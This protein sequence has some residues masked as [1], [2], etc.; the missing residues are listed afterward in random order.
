MKKLLLFIYALCMSVSTFAQTG[1]YFV[2]ASRPDDTGAG[3]SWATAKKTISAALTLIAAPGSYK[4]LFIAQG[5]Y[6]TQFTGSDR[7]INFYGGFPTG[8]GDGTFAARNWRTYPTIL[9]GNYPTNTVVSAFSFSSNAIVFD[10]FIVQNCYTNGSG[11]AS[12]IQ[13]SSS[14]GV[15]SNCIIRGCA[16]AGG[17]ANG[18]SAVKLT[19]TVG[20]TTVSSAMIKDCE[21]YANYTATTNRSYGG[22]GVH[23]LDG[24]TV[25]NCKIYN[26]SQLY[27]NPTTGPNG[28]SGAIYIQNS[29]NTQ[30]LK[31]NVYVVGNVIY[32]NSA[33]TG[34]GIFINLSQTN[35]AT[36]STIYIVNNTFA[37]NKAL[38]GTDGFLK[39]TLAQITGVDNTARARINVNNNIFW[40]NVDNATATVP[41][42]SIAKTTFTYNAIQGDV[43][44]LDASNKTLSA[45]NATDVKF[46]TP[47]ISAGCD[48][49]KAN[50]AG[51]QTASETLMASVW[52]IDPKSAA[53]NS[54]SNSALNA[55][56]YRAMYTTTDFAGNT[57]ILNSTIDM[58]AYEINSTT[59]G[60]TLNNQNNSIF[61]VIENGIVFKSN[62]FVEVISLSGK[63]VWKG[64]ANNQTIRLAKGAYIVKATFGQKV[65]VEKVIVR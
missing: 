9:D 60:I 17:N 49:A 57:R 48:L 38:S 11:T 4:N 13:M 32:N 63:S 23:I 27:S 37:N 24:G 15:I 34:S 62:S 64:L 7:R 50:Y 36:D 1:D 2:D 65:E 26:N 40:G 43:T 10:G 5:T 55:T 35:A 8:G 53:I 28:G 14:K 41:M 51:N 61:K 6:T 52:T 19:G 47:S 33:Y 46:T 42:A 16:S 18:G 3:T 30:K 58:G 12:G 20:S 59:T 22:S 54:G 21:I 29:T 44:G 56:Y 39:V 45:T 31:S 25:Q